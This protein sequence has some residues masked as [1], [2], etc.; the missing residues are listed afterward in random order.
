MIFAEAISLMQE[1]NK[2]YR[3]EFYK[4]GEMPNFY[5]MKPNDSSIYYYSLPNHNDFN[6]FDHF[7]N[8]KIIDLFISNVEI[9]D[10]TPDPLQNIKLLSFEEA[11]HE[12]KANTSKVMKRRY[13]KNSDYIII[14]SGPINLFLMHYIT[15][16]DMVVPYIITNEDIF[17]NDWETI[18]KI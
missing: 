5:Y 12:I 15:E 9:Y 14:T 6:I 18:N 13:W 4:E 8:A 17:A 2:I 10:G 11:L 7:S 3:P 1:G 16:L